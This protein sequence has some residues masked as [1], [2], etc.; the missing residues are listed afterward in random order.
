MGNCRV[1]GCD[2][3]AVAH[4]TARLC[5]HHQAGRRSYVDKIKRAA[6]L[7]DSVKVPTDDRL[8]P[9]VNYLPDDD[10]A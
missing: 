4:S 1:D 5:L 2:H 8:M 6:E 9:G 7:L 10:G 3:R